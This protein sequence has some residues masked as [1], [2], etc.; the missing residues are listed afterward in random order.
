MPAPLVQHGA[1]LEPRHDKLTLPWIP[2]FVDAGPGIGGMRHATDAPVACPQRQGG[3]VEGEALFAGPCLP[4]SST[5]EG[6]VQGQP[7]RR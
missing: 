3:Q 5:I 4:E 1:A 2:A 6:G 7:R